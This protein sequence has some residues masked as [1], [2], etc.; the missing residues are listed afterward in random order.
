MQDRSDAF[1]NV[2][3][4]HDD[5]ALIAF[6]SGTTGPPKATMHFHRDVLAMCDTYP[7]ETLRSGPDDI[8]SG[9]APLGFT[10]GLGSLLL[11]PMRRGSSTVLLEQANPELMLQ[12]AQDFGVTHFAARSDDVPQHVA[13][14]RAV[15]SFHTAHLLLGRRAFAGRSF[16]RVAAADRHSHPRL[17]GLNG[18]AARLHRRAARRH[19]SGF[20]RDRLARLSGH[21]RR[22][23]D[24]SVAARSCRAARRARP[25]RL[26]LP[27]RSVIGRKPTSS[28][29]GT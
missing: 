24:E 17:H 23:G 26:P 21:G 14:Y 9:S 19:S 16:R 1:P 7:A 20:N 6:T 28:T 8:F 5:V 13:S 10:Y 2:V 15:R 18:D 12:A 25:D 4:S 27:Q 11:F 3:P 29:D 22:R